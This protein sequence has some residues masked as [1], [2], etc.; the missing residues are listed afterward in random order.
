MSKCQ[1]RQVAFGSILGIHLTYYAATDCIRP[2]M[3]LGQLGPSRG[4]G[5][6]HGV[7]NAVVARNRNLLPFGMRRSSTDFAGGRA[8]PLAISDDAQ[9]TRRRSGEGV[10]HDDVTRSFRMP[11]VAVPVSC[12]DDGFVLAHQ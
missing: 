5:V 1:M 9:R 8:R 7:P 4:S 12:G 11:G 6:F 3:E 2:T 10:E